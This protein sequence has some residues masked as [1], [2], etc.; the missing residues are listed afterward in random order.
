MRDM[1]PGTISKGTRSLHALCSSAFLLRCGCGLEESPSPRVFADNRAS[2]D[3]ELMQVRSPPYS[4]LC[5]I[6]KNWWRGLIA[7]TIC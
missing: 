1:L 5:S 7:I 3:A 6:S 4:R 2:E